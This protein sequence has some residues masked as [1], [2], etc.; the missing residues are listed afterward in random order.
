MVSY[1]FFLVVFSNPL[2]VYNLIP[3]PDSLYYF[4]FINLSDVYMSGW[5]KSYS[6]RKCVH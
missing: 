5:K 3:A 1:V 6:R 4:A 2:K